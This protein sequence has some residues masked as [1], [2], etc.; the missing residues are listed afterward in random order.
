MFTYF[1][2]AGTV[3]TQICVWYAMKMQAHM[4]RPFC[5]KNS[6]VTLVQKKVIMS[7][8]AQNTNHHRRQNATARNSNYV[9][10]HWAKKPNSGTERGYR[11]DQRVGGRRLGSAFQR[12]TGKICNKLRLWIVQECCNSTPRRRRA[13]RGSSGALQ[14]S[15]EVIKSCPHYCRLGP[16][17]TRRHTNPGDPATTGTGI[18][19][20]AKC[21][22]NGIIWAKFHLFFSNNKPVS[23]L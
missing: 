16:H 19:Y 7:T 8:C 2:R 3:R 20:N 17:P 12:A 14:G 6:H 13:S 22:S 11:T 5:Q 21:I 4:I 9:K 18:P 1:L 23:Q 15:S 10:I